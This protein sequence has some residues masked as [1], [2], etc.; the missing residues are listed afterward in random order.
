MSNQTGIHDLE[1]SFMHSNFYPVQM[2]PKWLCRF[3]LL[4]AVWMAASSVSQA[5]V[6]LTSYNFPSNSLP[7]IYTNDSLPTPYRLR[8][9]FAGNYHGTNGWNNNGHAIES[10]PG[11]GWTTV[12]LYWVKYASDWSTILEIGPFNQQWVYIAPPKA[13]QT[14]WSQNATTYGNQPFTPTYSGGGGTGNWQFVVGGSTNWN[15][16]AGNPAGTNIP[17][18]GW[19]TSWTPPAPG[20]Y[21]FWVAK[22]GDSNYYDSNVAGPYTLTVQAPVYDWGSTPNYAPSGIPYTAMI[23][24]GNTGGLTY[25]TLYKNGAYSAAAWMGTQSTTTDYGVQTV[26]YLATYSC[27]STSSSGS[28]GR[29]VQIRPLPSGTVTGPATG[30]VNND[31]TYSLGSISNATDWRWEVDLP[32]GSSFEWQSGYDSSPAHTSFSWAFATGDGTYKI[33]VHLR[34]LSGDNYTNEVTVTVTAANTGPSITAHP[35]SQTVNQGSA[36]T[37]SVTAS[38]TA[39]LAYQWRKNGVDISNATSSS[40]SLSNVQPSDAGG[41]SAYVSNSWGNATSNTA[42]L[43]VNFAPSFTTQPQNQTV[44]VGANASFSVSA[45]GSPTPTYQ[46]Q[47]LPSG[48]SWSNLSNGGSYSGVNT[49]T[50][51]VSSVTTGMNNDQFRCV[52]TN[53]IST[54][55][56]NAATLTIG[57]GTQ[58]TNNQN[59]LNIHLPTP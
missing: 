49:A 56:S 4:A 2:I 15:P 32:G 8:A 21:S 25:V 35:S 55:T 39:P 53:S 20:T 42:T 27:S 31:N 51:T 50:L 29:Q 41:Y 30:V 3:V 16:T 40:Y 52:A 28:N 5:G 22:C 10:V 9:K 19:S 18:V 59:Q 45:S 23:N 33:K 6:Y 11:T 36:V 24:V 13:S 54:V 14:V 46:W 37:F 58:D 57:S 1:S 38:G 44:S 26:N 43:T 17:G 47:R 48:G 7:Q 34:G 12:E